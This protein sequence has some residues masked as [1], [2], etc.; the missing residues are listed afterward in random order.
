MAKKMSFFINRTL[1]ELENKSSELITKNT[2]LENALIENGELTNEI[3]KRLCYAAEY[4]D[5]D[6]AL[7]MVRMSIYASILYGK[8]ETSREKI[9]LM[10]YAAL[11]HD[12]GKIGIADS[13]LLKPGK[14]TREEFKIMKTH[15][16]IWSKNT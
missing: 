1:S 9:K 3:I 8:V 12:I 7:H 6:S 4:K 14:L 11:M 2:L 16:A 13:I 5:E 15:A 10:N